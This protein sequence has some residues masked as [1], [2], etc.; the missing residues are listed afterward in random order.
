M[1]IGIAHPGDRSEVIDYVLQRPT[2]ADEE[3]IVGSI[4]SGLEAL[5]M[6]VEQGSEKAMHWLHSRR[7]PGAIADGGK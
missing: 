3:L 6:F 1:R 7:A 4:G 5:K 2:Q